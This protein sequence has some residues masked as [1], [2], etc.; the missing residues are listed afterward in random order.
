MLL[1]ATFLVG[2]GSQREA[3]QESKFRWSDTSPAWSPDGQLIVFASDRPANK[4]WDLYVVDIGGNHL[5]R[6][7]YDKLHEEDPVFVSKRRIV[8]TVRRK[9]YVIRT[10]G[11]GRT[12]RFQP[13]H[14]RPRPASF[15]A[16]ARTGADGF[17]DV[18]VMRRDGS[19]KRLVAADIVPISTL[20]FV[21]HWSTDRRMFAFDGVINRGAQIY[22][23]RASVGAAKQVSHDP[24]VCCPAWSPDGKELAW[25]DDGVT[26][27]RKNGAESHR[28]TGREQL[29][30]SVVTW[31]KTGR[32][33]LVTGDGGTYVVNLDRTGLR[34]LVKTP[35]VT[36]VL[37]PD[38]T[39]AAFEEEGGP[40]ICPGY[41]I[42][43]C[44][45]RYSRIDIFDLTSGELRYVTQ[46][47]AR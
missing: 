40:E 43:S 6:V 30:A 20:G 4:Q 3:G 17:D 28:L 38:Q 37:S 42:S 29:G 35:N 44:Y 45:P 34:R 11:R 18:Y 41:G 5:R 12:R 16:F 32:R 46:K 26:V 1:V 22:V 15:V 14:S 39:R 19:A 2:C 23:V 9:R 27:A 47:R 31:P 21:P 25:A 13:E 7:T 8:F 33:L 10:D 36:V 24:G